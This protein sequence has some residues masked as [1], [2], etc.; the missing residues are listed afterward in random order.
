M[1]FFDQG[2]GS[3]KARKDA[4]DFLV[5]AAGKERDLRSPIPREVF[6]RFRERFADFVD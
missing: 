4:S 1:L 6:Q 5:A 2:G 3:A